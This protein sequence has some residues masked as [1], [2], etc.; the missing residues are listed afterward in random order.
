VAIA[1]VAHRGQIRVDSTAPRGEVAAAL[2]RA[3]WAAIYDTH[4]PAIYRYAYARLRSQEDAEDVA[5]QV[6]LEAIKGYAGYREMDRPI[7]AWLYG[8]ARNL[9]ANRVRR[10]VRAQNAHASLAQRLERDS[11][12]GAL[13]RVELDMAMAALTAEQRDVIILRF[14]SGL[15]TPE[16][17]EALQK[18]PEAV[19]SLQVRAIAA[20]RRRL[21][22]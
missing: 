8:I 19:Y 20:L 6:F 18:T 17:A 9:V 4:F 12:D 3:A 10:A 22:C 15:S 7:L 5:A 16:I 11:F 1:P 14:I 21:R 2:D 13:D